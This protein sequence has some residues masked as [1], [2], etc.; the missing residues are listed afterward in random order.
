MA[1]IPFN[2]SLGRE[3]E[4]YLRVLN[5]DP[6][7]SGLVLVV[8]THTGLETDAV[9]RLYDTLAALLV[10]ND[11]VQNVGYA[12]I[13]LTDV[14]LDPV[15]EDLDNNRSILPLDDQTFATISAGDTWS[16][17]V[18]CYDPDT[19]GGTDTTLIPFAAVDLRDQ[20]GQVGVPNGNDIIVSFP[21][22]LLHAS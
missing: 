19:T 17:L 7:T 4:F 14:D 12:R 16:K 22:G 9:L 8:L 15:T 13:V 20:F 6:A 18:V 21:D 10:N 11:E 2:V 3:V 1:Q 5:N